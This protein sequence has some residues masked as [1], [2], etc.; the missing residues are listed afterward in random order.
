MCNAAQFEGHWY[1]T[2]AELSVLVGGSQ[3]LVW[4]GD[5]ERVMDSCLCSVDLA[6]TLSRSGYSWERGLDPMERLASSGRASR[7]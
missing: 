5:V 7:P 6:A 3:R 4:N 2:P 1:R